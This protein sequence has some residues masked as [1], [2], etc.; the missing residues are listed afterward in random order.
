MFRLTLTFKLVYVD[1]S[2][3]VPSFYTCSLVLLSVDQDFDDTLCIYAFNFVLVCTR[4]LEQLVDQ[5]NHNT[6]YNH[7]LSHYWYYSTGHK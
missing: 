6:R 5:Q 3:I 2:C 1:I 7:K 4:V